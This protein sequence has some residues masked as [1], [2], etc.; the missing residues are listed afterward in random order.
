MVGGYEP[1][2]KFVYF[3]FFKNGRVVRTEGDIN[4]LKTVSWYKCMWFSCKTSVKT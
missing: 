3:V 2:Q 1:R 4:K